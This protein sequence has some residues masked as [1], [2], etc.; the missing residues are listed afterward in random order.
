MWS[1][2]RSYVQ[3]QVHDHSDHERATQIMYKQ[4]PS[5]WHSH[6]CQSHVLLALMALAC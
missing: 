4:A 2:C 3:L 1:R 6:A 5:W